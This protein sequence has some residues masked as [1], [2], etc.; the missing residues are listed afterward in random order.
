M[1]SIQVQKAVFNLATTILIVGG[2]LFYSFGIHGDVFLSKVMSL[3][4]WGVFILKFTVVM[5]AA[6][7]IF[8]ILFFL[9][10]RTKSSGKDDEDLDFLDERDKLIEIKSD[11][12][13]HWISS[14]GFII[15]MVP[16]AMGYSVNYM[17]SIILVFAIVSTLM[18]DVWKIYFYSKGD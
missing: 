5:V 8:F 12:Y 13:S 14:V 17:F 9:Y 4:F 10:K 16:I 6:K 18:L 15:S 3:Q 11:R 7:V 1:M 2:Y